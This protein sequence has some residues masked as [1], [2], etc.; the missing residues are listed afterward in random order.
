MRKT[1]LFSLPIC[2]IIFIIIIYIIFNYIFKFCNKFKKN[3]KI[4][5]EIIKCDKC[6]GSGLEQYN[7]SEYT[8]PYAHSYYNYYLKNKSCRYC[9]YGYIRKY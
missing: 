7:I 1:D 6:N 4:K 8:Y 3:N 5:Y 9:T 2:F